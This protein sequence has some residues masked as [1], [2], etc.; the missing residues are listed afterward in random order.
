MQ[1][2]PTTD[3]DRAW[4]IIGQEEWW[5]FEPSGHSDDDWVGRT[6]WSDDP[7]RRLVTIGPSAI[8]PIRACLSHPHAKV[9][10]AAERALKEIGVGA[11]FQNK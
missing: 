6:V 9:S 4:L 8:E 11:D 5:R 10:D 7:W 2:S 1:W 3:S